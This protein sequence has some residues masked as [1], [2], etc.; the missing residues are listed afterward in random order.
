MCPGLRPSPRVPGGQHALAPAS[1]PRRGGKVAVGSSAEQTPRCEENRRPAPG[2]S[3]GR[4]RLVPTGT[5]SAR[6][7]PTPPRPANRGPPAYPYP[8]PFRL[9]RMPTH[10]TW[11]RPPRRRAPRPAPPRSTAPSSPCSSARSALWP[12]PARCPAH[13]P[14]HSVPCFTRLLGRPRALSRQLEGRRSQ[15]RLLP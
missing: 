5:K 10:S 9:P 7:R 12:R 13:L 6:P 8:G 14:A 3:A 1:Q 4:G 2:H 15:V 11:H